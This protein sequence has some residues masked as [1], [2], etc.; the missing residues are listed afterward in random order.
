[1]LLILYVIP[2]K[3][4]DKTKRYSFFFTPFYFSSSSLSLRNTSKALSRFI[5]RSNTV[6]IRG[7]WIQRYKPE[8][9]FFRKIN[10]A[11]LVIDDT[12]IKVGSS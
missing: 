11:K 7:C 3:K 9:L 4:E 6:A 1:L 5:K 10:I 8:R 12:Q 2:D